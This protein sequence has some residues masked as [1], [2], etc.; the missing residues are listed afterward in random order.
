MN[1]DYEIDFSSLLVIND[2]IYNYVWG[3]IKPVYTIQSQPV[4]QQ[5]P[6]LAL[7]IIIILIIEL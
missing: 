7:D 1:F 5:C 3:I 6:S 2:W 4:F